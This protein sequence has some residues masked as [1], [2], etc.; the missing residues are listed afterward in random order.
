MSHPWVSI[1]VYGR[2]VSMSVDKLIMG[3]SAVLLIACASFFTGFFWHYKRLPPTTE[4]GTLLNFAQRYMALGVW[5]PKGL[6]LEADVAAGDPLFTFSET[7]PAAD[8]YR[9]IMAYDPA[10]ESYS[11]RLFDSTGVQ[12]HV[13]SVS[14]AALTGAGRKA[15]DPNPH[16]M[17]VLPDGSLAVSFGP[18]GSDL[19]ARIDS[20][21]EPVWKAEGAYHH[22]IDIDAEGRLWSWYSE[23]DPIG[24]L[25]S[26]VAL[27]AETG[28]MVEKI[29][30]Q[31][32]AETNPN[33]VK[34]LG[35][36]PGFVFR[37][38]THRKPSVRQDVFHP[39]DVEPL[40]PEMADQYP[41]FEAGDL[42]VSLRNMNLV[43]V[44]DADTH[45]FIWL[46]FGPWLRQHDPDFI[47]DG[48]ISVFDNG[49][50][51]QRSNV[52]VIDPVTRETK[53]M[54]ASQETFFYTPS[55][56]KHQ[57]LPNG[58]NL[59]TIPNEGRVLEIVADDQI[60]VEFNNIFRDGLNARVLNAVWVPESFYD[61]L[62]ACPP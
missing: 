18:D 50:G 14:Y 4:I 22:S 2:G 13:W 33:F 35:L 41:L 37:T 25:Q 9:I 62:P 17:Q 8:G 36:R 45:E 27:D 31:A 30:L 43:A 54:F 58:A 26:L 59:V 38:F 29:S 23:D 32:L 20:C 28:A 15:D 34:E 49:T 39:N 40:L 5:A 19:L 7:V 60:A 16:G 57:R 11:A 47:G 53:T 61:T 24:H 46:A 6:F 12:R 3:A 42:L 21:S 55:Q 52:V 10:F 1:S 44:M 56:G 48:L 51:R